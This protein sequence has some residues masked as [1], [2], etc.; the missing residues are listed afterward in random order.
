MREAAK[1]LIAR[2]AAAEM[3]ANNRQTVV[4]RKYPVGLRNEVFSSYA[5]G[6]NLANVL[7]GLHGG[8]QS[9]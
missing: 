8:I 2:A 6:Y 4:V 3:L 7:Y 1:G 5:E 9:T